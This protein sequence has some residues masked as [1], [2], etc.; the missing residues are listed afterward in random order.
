ME[1]EDIQ[2]EGQQDYEFDKYY[3]GKKI[4][5]LKLKCAEC[6]KEFQVPRLVDSIDNKLDPAFC[7]QCSQKKC[8]RCS[9]VLSKKYVCKNKICKN[10]H[11]CLPSKRE[12][13]RYCAECI[14]YIAL[15]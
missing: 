3:V 7:F 8:L 6:R 10:K 5:K 2:P 12:P 4:K 13:D 14:D 1:N 9:I 15:I 11:H